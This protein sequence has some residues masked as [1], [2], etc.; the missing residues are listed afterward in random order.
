VFRRVLTGILILVLLSMF[1][2]V[3]FN[4]LPADPAALTCGKGCS[5]QVIEANRIRLGLDMPLWQQYLEF[6]KG[7]FFG[8]T[9]GSGTATF[10]CHAPCLGYSFRRGQEVTPLILSVLPVTIYLAVGAFI[11]WITVGISLGIFAALRRGQWQDRTTLGAA[12]V[13][14]SFPSFFIGL[15][16]LFFVV[17]KW[18]L[19]PY[20]S[21]VPP[22]EN[23]VQFFQTMI[24]PWITLAL[25]FAAFYIRLTRNQMLDT[26]GEDYIRTA[27]SK[28]MPEHQVIRK[29]ALRAGLTPIVTAAGLDLAG[30]LGG[31][32]VTETVFTLP[33]LGRL[34]IQSVLDSDLP[35]ITATVLVAG[36]FIVV[37]N[38]I[39]D[40]LYAVI[41]PRVRLS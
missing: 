30:L 25:L 1:T 28:G 9:Y 16:L 36:F 27:R 2:F 40:L 18:Q 19:L 29:H 11:I 31:A 4:M 33:G 6:V 22:S 24:L 3:L 35:V 26:L 32:I 13:G 34:A 12:L 41:D 38:L 8:R 10:E 5:P 7:I 14:Y 21:Y 20:P 37:A 17:I 23:P 39:V 15:L